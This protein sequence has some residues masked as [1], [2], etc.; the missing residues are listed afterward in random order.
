MLWFIFK[1]ELFVKLLITYQIIIL[2]LLYAGHHVS[3]K[4][5]KVKATLTP[6][7]LRNEVLSPPADVEG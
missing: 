4:G 2:H 6:E 5:P 3:Y 1:Y 7:R